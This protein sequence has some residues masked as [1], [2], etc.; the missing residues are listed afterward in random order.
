M[1]IKTS[2]LENLVDPLGDCLSPEVARRILKLKS[3]PKLKQRLDSLATRH[4]EGKLSLAEVNEYRNYVTYG[5]F[6]A[7][8][9]SKSRQLLASQRG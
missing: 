6:V 7:I 2:L 4:R 3:S 8:L 1:K 5:T 9:K